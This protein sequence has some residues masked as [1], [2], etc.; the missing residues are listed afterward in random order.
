LWYLGA[1]PVAAAAP[2]VA[3][4]VEGAPGLAAAGAAPIV[5]PTST[6][7]TAAV[8]LFIV[9]VL[10]APGCPEPAP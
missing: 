8:N 1:T 3:L 9:P 10:R 5:P 7:Q 4:S 2:L 6:A